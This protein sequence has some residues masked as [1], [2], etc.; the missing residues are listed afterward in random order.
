ML[1]K[2]PKYCKTRTFA[3]VSL[4]ELDDQASILTHLPVHSIDM[5]QA[6]RAV[7]PVKRDGLLLGGQRD[8]DEGAF[9]RVVPIP[10][11]LQS[12]KAN[13]RLVRSYT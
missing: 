5:P 3:I 2:V 6:S 1:L 13:L 11:R 10:S 8:M 12:K 9:D 7:S 4:F